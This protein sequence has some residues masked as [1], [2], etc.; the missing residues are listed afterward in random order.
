MEYNNYLTM[1]LPNI[2]S[3]FF[4]SLDQT[5]P[6]MIET[7]Y[8]LMSLVGVLFTF[9]IF[10]TLAYMVYFKKVKFDKKAIIEFGLFSI[11]L[12]TFLLPHMHERYLFMGDAFGLLYL[13]INKKRFY[14]PL[15]I[16]LISLNGY[17]YSLF[18]GKTSNFNLFG[19]AFLVVVVIYTKDMIKKYF[20][21]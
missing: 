5:Y 15:T 18:Y 6:T 1:N 4:N 16:E 9:I 8:S 19:F 11:L 20:V 17:M 21:S 14:I 7:R 12:T 3:I 10:A 2:Y 13:I